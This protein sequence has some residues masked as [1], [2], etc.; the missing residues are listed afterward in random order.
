MNYINIIPSSCVDFGGGW[1]TVLQVSHCVH[2]CK[3][4]FNESSWSKNAGDL[5]TEDTYQEL[6]S[7]ASKSYISNVVMQGGEPLSPLNYKE[8]ITLCRRLRKD[9]PNINIV[10]FTGYTYE[11]IQN[12]ILRSHV[13]STIDYLVDGRYEQDNPTTKPFRGSDGQIIHKIINGISVEQS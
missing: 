9:L 6:L 12:D 7:Y 8:M 11:E 2:M 4:C 10:V 1:S 3:G 13:L 5:F